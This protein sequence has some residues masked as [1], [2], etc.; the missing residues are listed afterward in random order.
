[1]S[2]MP[3]PHSKMKSP[4]PFLMKEDTVNRAVWDFLTE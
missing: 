2:Y 4:D 1:M 3:K